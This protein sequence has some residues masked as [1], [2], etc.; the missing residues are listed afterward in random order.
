MENHN[1]AKSQHKIL[2]MIKII[3]DLI[4]IIAIYLYFIGWL[5]QYFVLDNFGISLNALNIPPY[6]FFVY[7]YSVIED[8]YL[9]LLVVLLI[10]TSCYLIVQAYLSKFLLP[11][12]LILTIIVFRYSFYLSQT[13][14]VKEAQ[15]IRSGHAHKISFVFKKKVSQF[16]PK[17]FLDANNNINANNHNELWLIIQATDGYYVLYQHIPDEE[18]IPSGIVYKVNKS[19]VILVITKIDDVPYPKGEINE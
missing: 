5:Y 14:A 16:L 1:Q 8:H 7:A 19:D 13:T 10:A 2:S 12:V 17:E 6:Y 9:I 15:A 18:V 4:L 3:R 11:A